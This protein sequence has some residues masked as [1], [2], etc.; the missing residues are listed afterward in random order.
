MPRKAASIPSNGQGQQPFLPGWEQLT[1]EQQ[2]ALIA[3]LKDAASELADQYESELNRLEQSAAAGRM[4]SRVDG[5]GL[6]RQPIPPLPDLKRDP[7]FESLALDEHRL[8]TL[9]GYLQ[10][11]LAHL[12]KQGYDIGVA[13]SE[14][15]FA[16]T[17]AL[18]EGRV[19]AHARVLE[20]TARQAYT[21]FYSR[22]V[23]V[24]PQLSMQ[25]VLEWDEASRQSDSLWDRLRRLLGEH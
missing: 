18:A 19:K 16:R 10:M 1:Q 17:E 12:A 22:V 14:Y 3:V 11:G 23:N 9:L 20:D 24:F 15:T 25:R 6:N 13:L 7:R 4:L 21:G 5:T 8:L 2:Q